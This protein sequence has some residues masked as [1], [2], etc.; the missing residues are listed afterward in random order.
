[1]FVPV[2]SAATQARR[3]GYFR[4]DCKIA[5]QRTHAMAEG[6]PFLLP[7]VIDG[8]RDGDAL[9]PAEFWAVQWTRLSGDLS[10]AQFADCVKGLLETS[11]TSAPELSRP[12]NRREENSAPL[13]ARR[14][15]TI[16]AFVLAAAAVG[17][18]GSQLLRHRF[19]GDRPS[20]GVNN[21]TPTAPAVSP[22]KEL[23]ARSAA[24]HDQRQN[25][26]RWDLEL[27]EQLCK[28][29]VGLDPNDGEVR[30]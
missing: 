22:A 11:E 19:V 16:S 6:T 2:I 3:E 21:G 30:A 8:K 26:L 15:L 20:P 24:L 5:A 13:R 4:L 7:V 14:L 27:A 18:T 9:V 25:A 29:A 1:M 17:T 28:Q 10:P 12:V 23:V